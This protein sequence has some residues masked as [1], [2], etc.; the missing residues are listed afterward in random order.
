LDQVDDDDDMEEMDI[1][2]QV[3]LLSLKAKKF[4]KRTGRKIIINGNETAGFDKKKVECYNC[5]KMG[6]FAKECRKPKKPYNRSTWYKQDKKKEPTV[7]E[8]KV[9]LA[10]N[11]VSYDW[12]YMA[13]E[14]EASQESAMIATEHAL[15]AFSDSEVHSNNG[16]S[17]S[18]KALKEYEKL[19]EQY[20]EQRLELNQTSYNLSNHKRGLG[21]LEAQIEHFRANESKFNDDIAVLRRDLDYKI[22]VNEALREE[23]EKIK[24]A[25]ENIQITC[26][27]LDHQSKCIDKIW[28]AQVVNKV[29]S[30]VGYKS[31]PPPLRDVPSP[32][33]IDLAHT[34]LEDFQEPIRTYVP[35]FVKEVIDEKVKV[36]TNAFESASDSSLKDECVKVE[37]KT[38]VPEIVKVEVKTSVPEV[39]KI[40]NEKPRKQANHTRSTTK[41]AEMYRSKS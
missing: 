20:D 9:L 15:M 19:K 34:W 29:K 36:E 32:P 26:N 33:G 21:V 7:E 10:I 8:P 5:H 13:D 30:C 41:Y 25:N 11:G 37:A 18:C 12:S 27:T 4:W 6:H 2:W 39:V 35:K 17:K 3:A 31:V 23:L 22:A 24:K 16:C 40:E 14:E 38:S 28:E 1:K